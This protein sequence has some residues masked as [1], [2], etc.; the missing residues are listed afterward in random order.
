MDLDITSKRFR[1][2]VDSQC[3]AK[4]EDMGTWVQVS[5]VAGFGCDLGENLCKL[6]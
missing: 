3:S 5:G 6:R 2:N 4:T 1:L